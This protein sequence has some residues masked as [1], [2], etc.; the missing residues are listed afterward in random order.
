MLEEV[1][2]A[3]LGL[4]HNNSMEIQKIISMYTVMALNIYRAFLTR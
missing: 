4:Y 3:F 2:I 1:A